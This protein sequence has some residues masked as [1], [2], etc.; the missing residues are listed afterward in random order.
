MN[1]KAFLAGLTITVVAQILLNAILLLLLRDLR[2]HV[3]FIAAAMLIMMLF[4]F[5]L[6]GAAR[7]MAKS[8]QAS[9][10]IQL[11]M[12]AVFVKLLLCL[13]LVVIYK[14]AF[15]PPNLSF[16]WSFLIIYIS[17]TVY[18]VVFLEKVGRQKKP[19]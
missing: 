15:H 2:E 12:I 3:G 7:I 10:F 14:E 9:L 6:Y 19:S 13:A 4:C 5:L 17:T 1:R 16:V 11:V 18:E 8:S